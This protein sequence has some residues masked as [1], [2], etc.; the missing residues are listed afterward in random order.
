MT[1]PNT[2]PTPSY[3]VFGATGGIGES[4]CRRLASRGARIMIAARNADRLQLLADELHAAAYPLDATR[5]EEV[6]ACVERAIQLRGRLDGIANCVGSLLLKP[7]HSTS[8]AEWFYT[9]AT[10]LTSAFAVVRAGAKAMMN[11][12][13]SIVLVSSATARVGL[14]NHEAIAAA[15]AGGHRPDSFG[16]GDLWAAPHP[17]QLRSSR[18]GPQP[19]D[20]PADRQRSLSEALSPVSRPQLH[21]PQSTSTPTAGCLAPPLCQSIGWCYS[22]TTRG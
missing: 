4:L 14:A 7:A 11:A 21:S 1:P 3:L 5:F 20:F 19:D 22:I 6:E 16:S 9:I 15:K 12:G 10:N 17:S 18:F 2:D 8:E 13:G